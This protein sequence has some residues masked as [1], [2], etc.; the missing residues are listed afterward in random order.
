[1]QAGSRLVAAGLTLPLVCVPPLR[2]AE[3]GKQITEHLAALTRT[4]N[5]DTGAG[6]WRRWDGLLS[7]FQSGQALQA[8][9]PPKHVS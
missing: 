9:Q 5:V 2:P 3:G 6:A 1:M 4:L 8:E 7:I